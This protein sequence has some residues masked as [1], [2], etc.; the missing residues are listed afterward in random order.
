MNGRDL[1]ALYLLAGLPLGLVAYRRADRFALASMVATVLL[2]PLWAPFSVLAPGV[3]KTPR[4]AGRPATDRVE[5]A[6]SAVEDAARGSALPPALLGEVR[7][8]A[9][10]LGERLAE[11]EAALSASRALLAAEAG[12]PGPGP[13]AQRRAVERLEQ[14]RDER[15]AAL[16]GLLGLLAALSASLTLSR[17]E[18][19]GGGDELDDL[20]ARLQAHLELLGPK[21]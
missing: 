10:R 21:G 1:A 6:L 16:D 18:A 12:D 3:G 4:A 5:R 19:P 11:L 20:V 8:A 17:F 2:W 15:T 7:A 9:V 14:L 13:S